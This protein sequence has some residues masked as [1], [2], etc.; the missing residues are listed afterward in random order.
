MGVVTR[1][2]V[3]TLKAHQ[4]P[5]RSSPT[6]WHALRETQS[7][8]DVVGQISSL[9]CIG[10]NQPVRI[11]Q[12]RLPTISPA[13]LHKIWRLGFPA[14]RLPQTRPLRLMRVPSLVRQFGHASERFSASYLADRNADQIRLYRTANAQESGKD[15]R[16]PCWNNPKS[17]M[18]T[19]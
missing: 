13:S 18:Y 19:W 14:G 3:V 12:R 1:C 2:R 7:K 16:Q 5:G 8:V 11:D 17:L 9:G 4:T 10:A 15:D 6:T